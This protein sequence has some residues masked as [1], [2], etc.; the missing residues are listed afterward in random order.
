MIVNLLTEHH[1]VFLSLIG[2]CTDSYEPTLVKVPLCWKSHATA[3]FIKHSVLL[4]MGRDMFN[5]GPK[6]TST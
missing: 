5:F 3:H 2:G 4:C 6:R 1:L